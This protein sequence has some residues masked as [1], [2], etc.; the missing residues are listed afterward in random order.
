MKK[1]IQTS[2]KINGA[3]WI[4]ERQ[5]W[6]IQIV[7]TDG[8]DL[9]VSDGVS[10]EGEQGE[11]FIEECDIFINASGAYNNWRW[12]NIPNRELFKGTMIHSASWPDVDNLTGRTAILIGNGS[13]GIQ[14]LP[15][16]LEKV[17]KIYVMLR[18]KTWVTPALANRFAGEDGANKIY[19]EDEKCEWGRNRGAYY[20]YRKEIEAELNVR[21]RLYL[22]GSQAQQ[23][24]RDGTTKQMTARLSAKPELVKDLIPDF[25]VG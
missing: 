1:Y 18:S 10:R 5:K 4:E 19:T 2:H 20:A 21:F 6:Q 11:V 23:M 12:P 22:K 14:I 7:Q 17:D 16:I 15:S 13:S 3:T 24:G 8:R 25:P 9:V